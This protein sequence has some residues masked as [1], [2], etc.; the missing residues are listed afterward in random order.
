MYF[1][2]SYIYLLSIIHYRSLLKHILLDVPIGTS[3][4]PTFRR[5]KIEYNERSNLCA[6]FM[7]EHDT[8]QIVLCDVICKYLFPKVKFVHKTIDLMFN[9]SKNQSEVLFCNV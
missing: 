4:L 7:Q 8:F 9:L 6:T 3:L 5:N 1:F 2:K